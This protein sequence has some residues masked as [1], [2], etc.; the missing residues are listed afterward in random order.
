[1]ID[2]TPAPSADFVFGTQATDAL[3]LA[4][5]R[6]ARA[7]LAH[8]QRIDPPDPRPGEPVTVALS[9]GPRVAADHAACYYTTDGSEPAGAR[10]VATTGT[11]LAL[12]RTAVEWDTLL[13]GYVETWAATIPPQP[14]GTLVRYRLEAWL[15]RADASHWAS[16][17]AGVIGGEQP[18]HAEPFDAE[19]FAVPGQPPL[20]P[21][22]RTG[23]YAYH[24]DSEPVPAW[25]RDAV[26]Y[27]VFVDRFAPDPGHSFANPA[28]LD[29][30][31]GGTLR[32]L[33]ERLD[34]IAALGAT[35]LWLS[36]IFPSP[37]HHGY[38]ATDY[39]AV[40]PRLGSAADLRTLLGAAHARGLRVVLD[41]AA[42]HISSE[43]PA[44]RAA[45]ADAESAAARWFT[46]T[47]WPAHYLSFFGVA[48][49]PQIDSDSPPA[50]AYMIES[51]CGWLAQGVDGFRLDYA[52]GPSHAFWSQ[53]RAATRAIRP[54]SVTFGEVIEPA[55]QL[56]AYAGRMDG[57]LDFVLMQALRACFAFGTLGV[58]ALDAFL[59]RH[60]AFFP[61][62]FTLPSFLDNHDM[63][64]FLWAAGGDVRR[65]RLAA[66]CQFTL[67]HPPIVYYGTEVGLSQAR[68]VRYPEGGGRLEESR[69]P[70]LWGAAQDQALLAFYRQLIA[71]RRRHAGLWRARRA[72]LLADDASGL[73]VV[74]CSDDSGALVLALNNGPAAQRFIAP[75][76]GFELALC[77]TADVAYD[78]AW[79]SLPPFGGAALWQP[80][81]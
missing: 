49:M 60:L 33:T 3:R 27:Q 11:V 29:G 50:R 19:L 2:Q 41:Y 21:V 40:E 4:Q 70:M 12:T 44:F 26:I 38:D 65:L 66:L 45:Q 28:A 6:A 58:A 77:T 5:L 51:A 55:G 76:A 73:Y 57:C 13:W 34:Y 56:L 46:F 62:D 24:V 30:F 67:P 20:W 16:E 15:A 35:C 64:R 39:Q 36:P 17:I 69:L 71:L 47:R 25:L 42:N 74:C 81:A 48:H 31:Y 78:G 8:A 75:G 18:A 68:D 80:S 72:T 9:I 52:N 10:G 1:M 54:D 79:L 14:A 23:S 53:F 32:G 61:G 59:G 43:H 22:R 7:G 37:S 63:N